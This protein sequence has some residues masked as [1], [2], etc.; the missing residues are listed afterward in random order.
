M[1]SQFWGSEY[2]FKKDLVYETEIKMGCV[3]E[4]NTK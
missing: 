1:Q 4:K 2:S 3:I